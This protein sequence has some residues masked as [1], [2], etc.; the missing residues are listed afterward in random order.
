MSR[1]LK[2]QLAEKWKHD[3]HG[4]VVDLM[5]DRNDHTFFCVFQGKRLT[6]PS[7]DQLR[8]EICKAVESS[9]DLTW[10]P[11]ITVTRLTPFHRNHDSV[12]VG[13]ELNRDWIAKRQDSKWLIAQ[14]TSLNGETDHRTE[15]ARELYIG[16]DNMSDFSLPYK[17]HS[18]VTSYDSYYIPY[19]DDIWEAMQLIKQ[20]I[21]DIRDQLHRL[22]TTEEGIKFLMTFATRML[23]AGAG[24]EIIE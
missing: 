15:F 23:T 12:F 1:L 9:F 4:S 24:Q 11:M 3:K 6:Q 21:Q 19:T 13:F 18:S 5:L 10:I 7:L 8:R 20:R 17:G 22:L 16:R 2:P 14:W